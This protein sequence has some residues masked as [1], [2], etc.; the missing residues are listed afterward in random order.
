MGVFPRERIEGIGL[1]RRNV[2]SRNA[3]AVRCESDEDE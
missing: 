3:A 1:L 2:G